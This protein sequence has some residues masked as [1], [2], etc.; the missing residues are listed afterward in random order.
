MI[1]RV[2]VREERLEHTHRSA[3]RHVTH[4]CCA[5]AVSRA[6]RGRAR[7]RDP[8]CATHRKGSWLSGLMGTVV[9]PLVKAWDRAVWQRR[10]APVRKKAT[11]TRTPGRNSSTHNKHKH[12]GT[13]RIFNKN[14][15]TNGLSKTFLVA[16]LMGFLKPLAS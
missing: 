8:C 4:A 10:N 11:R 5:I 6:H 1:S 15:L 7:A 12:A 9:T 3:R 13:Q 14:G 16:K 2:G